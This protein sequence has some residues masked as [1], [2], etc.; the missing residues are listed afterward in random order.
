MKDRKERLKRS[1]KSRRKKAR[2]RLR[3]RGFLIFLATSTE[4]GHPTSPTTTTTTIIGKVRKK[5]EGKNKQKN[6]ANFI[7]NEKN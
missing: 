6:E 4:S 3:R 7:L 5:E 2:V 1:A